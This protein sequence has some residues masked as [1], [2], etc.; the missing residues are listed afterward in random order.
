[1]T[2]TKYRLAELSEFNLPD[3]FNIAENYGYITVFPQTPFSQPRKYTVSIMQSG[4]DISSDSLT[5]RAAMVQLID[6]AQGEVNIG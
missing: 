2:P 3:L 4:Q 6:R 5:L 1:M